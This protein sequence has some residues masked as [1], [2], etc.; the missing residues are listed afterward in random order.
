M[1]INQDFYICDGCDS[2]IYLKD[3]GKL[4]AKL[5]SPHPHYCPS[6]HGKLV[7]KSLTEKA[8]LKLLKD[9]TDDFKHHI[10]YVLSSVQNVFKLTKIKVQCELCD[11]IFETSVGS[12]LKS[13]MKH[14]KIL[15]G[16]CMKS[17]PY[18]DHPSIL[19]HNAHS[20]DI[21]TCVCEKCGTFFKKE[22]RGAVSNFFNVVYCKHCI[23]SIR[24]SYINTKQ[25]GL[26]Y[27]QRYGKERADARKKVLS[28]KNSGSKNPMFGKP[29]PKGSG[30][31]WSGHYH[32]FYFR[33]ILEL[34]FIVNV[35]EKQNL[36]VESGEKTKFK[37]SYE[38]DNEKRTYFP[39]YVI[40]DKV[41]EIKPFNLVESTVVQTK[42][43]AAEK[44]CQEN[45]K[46]YHIFTEKD[47]QVL[48]T[49]E[50]KTLH[51]SNEIKFIKRYEEKYQLCYGNIKSPSTANR[52]SFAKYLRLS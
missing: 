40:E 46:T 22:R 26:S 44:W 34:S 36:Q 43:L 24:T 9:Y 48:S 2:V 8:R 19:A 16:R 20:H 38:I 1:N 25:A 6:C 17:P 52:L 14:D 5:A 31:G 32:G 42:K 21:V 3:K 47:F 15:C 49:E 12:A 30:N 45:R 4:Q 7:Q 33:S 23:V 13:I 39:D 51:D 37:I 10:K 29:S 41:F 18:P 35:I 28:E 50:I 11:K 27:E